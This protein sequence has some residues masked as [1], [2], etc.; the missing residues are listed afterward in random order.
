MR[1]AQTQIGH[2][3]GFHLACWRPGDLAADETAP[4]M[5]G[6]VRDADLDRDTDNRVARCCG[7]NRGDLRGGA[8]HGALHVVRGH[9]QQLDDH[10]VDLHRMRN[11]YLPH[12]SQ[13]DLEANL[14]MRDFARLSFV[15]STHGLWRAQS[16]ASHL[17]P[18]RRLT[19]DGRAQICLALF[20]GA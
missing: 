20:S 12:Y 11:G 15:R 6:N 7:A 8:C 13:I 16:P 18:Y 2:H 9:D 10:R 1:Y 5:V 4:A 17:R 14:Q 3:G 19:R